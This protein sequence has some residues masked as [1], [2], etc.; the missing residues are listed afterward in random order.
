[1]ADTP[2]SPG[3][4]SP[5]LK[6]EEGEFYKQGSPNS[7]FGGKAFWTTPMMNVDVNIVVDG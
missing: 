5:Q 6:D 7:Q 3:M 2:S 1:M 4:K